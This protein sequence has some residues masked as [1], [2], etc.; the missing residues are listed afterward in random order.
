MSPRYGPILSELDFRVLRG[1][2]EMM[3]AVPTRRSPDFK[4]KTAEMR[5]R[6][7]TIKAMVDEMEQVIAQREGE[8]N[9]A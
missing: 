6:L 5:Q 3:D 1:M 2:Q 4:A 8:G 9:D 7:E